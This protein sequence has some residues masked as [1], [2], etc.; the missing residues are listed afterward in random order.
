MDYK[1]VLKK[2][3]NPNFKLNIKNV[4]VIFLIGILIVLV[5]SFFKD[6]TPA[7]SPKLSGS[8]SPGVSGSDNSTSVS[9]YE[10]KV[11][12]ELSSFLEKVD[13][14]GQVQVMLNFEAGE[15]QVP[16]Y[17]DNKS[18]TQTGEKDNDG[19]S[20]TTTSSTDGTTVVQTTDGS[21]TKPLILKKYYPK[22]TSVF[23][24]AEGA[25]NEVTMLTIQQKVMQYFGLPESKV[26]VLPL[27]K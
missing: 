2:M 7:I 22:V 20:R 19:G 18:T 15:E 11:S 24:A 14:V 5:A 17:N 13:G 26:N 23:I 12:N 6:S 10:N 9:D 1:D 8:S 4:V 16:A 25:K 3:K 27:K 21:Q